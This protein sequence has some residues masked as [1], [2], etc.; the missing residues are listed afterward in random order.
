[1]FGKVLISEIHKRDGLLI[2][3]SA[4]IGSDIEPKVYV[5]KNNKA[6]LQSISIA[7][8]IKNGIVVSDGLNAG[9]IIITGGFINLSEGAFVSIKN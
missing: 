7:Q 4:V 9:D 6:V 2:P 8:R 1:M 5:V 3:S